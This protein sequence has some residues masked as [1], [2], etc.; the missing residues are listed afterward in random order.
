MQYV[1]LLDLG[2]WL[3]NGSLVYLENAKNCGAFRLCRRIGSCFKSK[4]AGEVGYYLARIN[5]RIQ[6][7]D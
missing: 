3:S 5:R 7:N 2:D 1:A 6:P 4:F